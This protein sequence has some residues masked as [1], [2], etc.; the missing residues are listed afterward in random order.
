MFVGAH[1]E[2]HFSFFFY[3]GRGFNASSFDER[4][5]AFWLANGERC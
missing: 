3:V 2:G 4:Y 5:L 1:L